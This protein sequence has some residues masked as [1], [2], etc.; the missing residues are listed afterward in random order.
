MGASSLQI[1]SPFR[2]SEIQHRGTDTTIDLYTE[3][4]IT[5]ITI[6]GGTGLTNLTLDAGASGVLQL[7]SGG[8]ERAR[9]NN[10][11]T[12]IIGTDAV[13]VSAVP[14]NIGA[15]TPLVIGRNGGVS[16][17]ITAAGGQPIFGLYQS[18]GTLSSP[19]VS[20][21][22]D[23]LGIHYWN[24]YTSAGHQNAAYILAQAETT[25][26]GTGTATASIRFGTAD[27]GGP[28]VVTERWRI[29]NT[30][31]LL[32]ATD[33]TYDIGATGA[34]RP[35]RV[36]VGTEVVVGNTVTI[37]TNSIVANGNLE[38]TSGAS[39]NYIWI[40]ANAVHDIYIG[41]ATGANFVEIDAG[42]AGISI[43]CAGGDIQFSQSGSPPSGV[44]FNL[45][46]NFQVFANGTG[47]ELAALAGDASFGTSDGNV[48]I[49]C[50]GTGR[51]LALAY[52]DGTAW[53][54]LTLD[55]AGVTATFPGGGLFTIDGDLVVT[56]NTTASMRTATI[57]DDA[58]GTGLILVQ[59]GFTSIGDGAVMA[60]LSFGPVYYDQKNGTFVRFGNSVFI[61]GTSQVI[62]AGDGADIQSVFPFT[63]ANDGDT[64]S[65]A[66][67]GVIDPDP[68]LP[69]SVTVRVVLNGGTVFSE[70]TD[71]GAGNFAAGAVLP[72]GGTVN[73]AA[74]TLTGTTAGLAK[75]SRVEI[76]F[77]NSNSAGE[78]LTVRAG[79][80]NGTAV[81]GSLTLRS[82]TGTTSGNL[83]LDVGAGS[84]TNGTVSLGA[85]NASA[86]TIGRT[87]VTT[88]VSGPLDAD[89]GITAAG[90]PVPVVLS[91]TSVDL[92]AVGATNLYTV[93]T[94]KSLVVT[95][96]YLK[97][98]T[99]TAA[100]ADAEGGVGVAAGEDD[101]VASQPLAGLDATSEV[102]RMTLGGS[103]Y[104]AASTEVVKFGVDVAD[105]GTA[106][107]ADVYLVG[108]LI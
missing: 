22:A 89:E 88:T 61:D 17:S 25:Y 64:Y 54:A 78:A 58:E 29:M 46:G 104:V 56:G 6:G 77:V 10:A 74:R 49:G 85:T 80:G 23:I 1:D 70:V 73:Y 20:A 72:A 98:T 60:G 45:N 16:V 36:Y 40:G 65:L 102:F 62:R 34:T 99:A 33:N 57:G 2:V 15:G 47:L 106:L 3:N 35:R 105:S 108:Y 48:S 92:A 12:L 97:P 83:V 37:G 42:T 103:Y 94:G 52:Q 4:P 7:R 71:D 24:G 84:S 87:G 26:A 5:T 68:L 14:M 11:G 32:A 101:I 51:A 18:N 43:N 21:S 76:A 75:G 91:V 66:S 44:L 50:S 13:G 79:D 59:R 82:G 38:L 63:A 67:A 93:P 39:P 53:C 27:A 81:G 30:G 100:N 69:G 31:H 41:E 95:D 90:L 9:L 55:T 86:I 107:V 19:T 28:N 8:A 96:V